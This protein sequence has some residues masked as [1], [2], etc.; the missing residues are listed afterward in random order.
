MRTYG[1][2]DIHTSQKTLKVMYNFQHNFQT[3]ISHEDTNRIIKEKTEY[4][5]NTYGALD[6][7]L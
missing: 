1:R 2:T 5:I 6:V 3:S 4:S 7:R